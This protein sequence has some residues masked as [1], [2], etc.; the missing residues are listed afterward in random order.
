VGT[1]G[2]PF[3]PCGSV[4]NAGARWAWRVVLARWRRV[5]VLELDPLDPQPAA[6]PIAMIT[7]NGAQCARAFTYS[8]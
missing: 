6:S 7:M 3:P 2:W 8:S 5:V 1:S 4:G